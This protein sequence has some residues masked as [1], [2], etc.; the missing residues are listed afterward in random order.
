MK[1]VTKKAKVY[2]SDIEIPPT[3]MQGL[4]EHNGYPVPWFVPFEDGEPRPHL[5]DP[6]KILLAIAMKLCWVC[7]KQIIPEDFAFVLG[8]MCTI[9]RISAEPPSHLECAIYSAR[10]CPFLRKPNMKRRLLGEGESDNC[11]GYMIERN[12]GCVCVWVTNDFKLEHTETGTLHRVGD[13]IKVYWLSEGRPATR[14][15][16]EESIRTGYP[17]LMNLCD[18]DVRQIKALEDFAKRAKKYLPPA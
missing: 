12:P 4:A 11:A 5:A 14:A 9:N 8:P 7:G 2:R 6:E 13:P 3:R 17:I 15:E 10:H 1:N 16:V 18:G